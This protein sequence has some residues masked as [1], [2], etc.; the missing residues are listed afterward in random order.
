MGGAVTGGEERTEEE[1]KVIG[2]RI[3]STVSIGPLHLSSRGCASGCAC[4]RDAIIIHR[5]TVT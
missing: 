1:K 3:H 2:S 4:R 5:V